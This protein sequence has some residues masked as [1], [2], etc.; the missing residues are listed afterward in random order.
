MQQHPGI[1]HNLEEDI[2]LTEDVLVFIVCLKLVWPARPTP[3][4][5]FIMLSFTVEGEGSSNSC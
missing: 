5:L 2:E 1:H 4:L 3:P